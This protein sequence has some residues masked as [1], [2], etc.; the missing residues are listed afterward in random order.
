MSWLEQLVALQ[1]DENMAG[2]C[3]QLHNRVSYNLH[4]IIGAISSRTKSWME[5]TAQRRN[6]Y[7]IQVAD[8]AGKRA[9]WGL[10]SR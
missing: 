2:R 3:S 1:R 8:L 10:G 5:R 9:L 6:I 4:I 7:K